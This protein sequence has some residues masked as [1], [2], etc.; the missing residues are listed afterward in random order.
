MLVGGEL[1]WLD[2]FPYINLA[3][4]NDIAISHVNINKK[5]DICNLKLYYLYHTTYID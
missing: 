2:Y 1:N 5:I 3:N 4:C